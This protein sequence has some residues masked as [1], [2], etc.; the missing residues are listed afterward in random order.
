MVAK[1]KNPEWEEIFGGVVSQ[2]LLS[3]PL[4]SR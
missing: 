2:T 3:S 1:M 4:L